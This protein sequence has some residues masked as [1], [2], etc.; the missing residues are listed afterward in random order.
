[1]TEVVFFSLPLQFMDS[2]GNNVA[3]AKYEQVV[4]EFYYRPTYRD[5]M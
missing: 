2:V 3:K 4:P 5:C 1:M